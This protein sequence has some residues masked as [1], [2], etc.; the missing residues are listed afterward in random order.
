MASNLELLTSICCNLINYIMV[1]DFPLELNILGREK[2][3]LIIDQMTDL[4]IG[5]IN[6][7]EHTGI[8]TKEHSR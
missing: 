6:M 3:N 7:M 1:D 2:L 8:L 4:V 5:K